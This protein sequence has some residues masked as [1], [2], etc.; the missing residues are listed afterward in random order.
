MGCGSIKKCGCTSQSSTC[1]NQGSCCCAKT[2][3]FNCNEVCT[4]LQ[5]A[6]S[7]NIP[8][9]DEAAQ[10]SAPCVSNIMVGSWIYNPT[11]GTFR[12]S[13]VNSANYTFNVINECDPDNA[14][15]GTMVPALTFFVFGAPPVRTAYDDWTPVLTG[16]ALMTT[17][18]TVVNEANWF[19]V[20]TTVFFNLSVSFTIGGTPD[21]EVYITLPLEGA[22]NDD[23][24]A[25]V[26][27]GVDGDGTALTAGPVWRVD[28]TNGLRLVVRTDDLGTAWTAGADA[29]ID[30]QGF[31]QV[32]T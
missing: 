15:P 4:S 31:Y 32:A 22:G 19:S 18:A 17:T 25:F 1:C 3:P 21:D 5:I 11:Y 29:K 23:L 7:W 6:N 16:Q 14:P 8:D 2:D 26:A 27:S 24:T 30:I 13:S 10:L 28:S 20:G 9:C 12:I